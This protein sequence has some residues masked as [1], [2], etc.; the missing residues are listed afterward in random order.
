MLTQP[1]D[2]S[3]D[4]LIFEDGSVF[5]TNGL[6]VSLNIKG[7]LLIE[8]SAEIRSFL[9]ASSIPAAFR[10]CEKSVPSTPA[11]GSNGATYC[12]GPADCDPSQLPPDNTNGRPGGG[13][14]VAEAMT[15]RQTLAFHPKWN[16][17]P[18]LSQAM[19]SVIFP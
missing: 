18:W 2:G 9:N 16:R 4:N 3:F 5:V 8:G 6:R 11:R 15:E 12:V 14:T 1:L 7:R 10:V 17:F 19:P 13:G